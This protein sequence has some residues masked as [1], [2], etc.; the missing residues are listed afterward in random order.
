MTFTDKV[1]LITGASSGIGAATAIHFSS[2]NAKLVLTGRN[3]E[4]LNQVAAKCAGDSKPLLVIADVN[5]EEDAK[6]IIE[7][8][9]KH[10]GKLDVL[11]NN[12]GIIESGG[13][14]DTNLEQYDRIFETN[15]RSIYRLTILAVPELIKTKG[16]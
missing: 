7:S 10:F 13:I 16:K 1:V 15:V 4:N 12:A 11:V 5:V 6:N 8:T 2:L 14:E 3:A 9:V